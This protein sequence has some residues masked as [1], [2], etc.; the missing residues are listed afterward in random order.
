MPKMGWVFQFCTCRR[1]VI[2]VSTAH[3]RLRWQQTVKR[4]RRRRLRRHSGVF[5][6]KRNLAM[7]SMV[8][9]WFRYCA[10]KKSSSQPQLVHTFRILQIHSWASKLEFWRLL[11]TRPS[12]TFSLHLSNSPQ[13]H[14]ILRGQNRRSWQRRCSTCLR[15]Q[16]FSCLPFIFLHSF[17]SCLLHLG[18]KIAE[19]AYQKLELEVKEQLGW[20]AQMWE[21]SVAMKHCVVCLAHQMQLWS[22]VL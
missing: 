11:L 19:A 7:V 6:C 21:A 3:V 16:I 18:A 17:L 13:R 20:W 15:N 12:W 8:T 22:L 4:R 1:A 9:C 2:A 10:I 14:A 5:K